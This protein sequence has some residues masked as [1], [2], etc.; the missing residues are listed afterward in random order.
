MTQE[1]SARK[2]TTPD[3]QLH[4]FFF[5]QTRRRTSSA[6]AYGWRVLWRL[7]GDLQMTFN[8]IPP[9]FGSAVS[10]DDTLTH[11]SSLTGAARSAQTRSLRIMTRACAVVLLCSPTAM[12]AQ[13]HHQG[14]GGG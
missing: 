3:T 6:R 13:H 4:V 8:R 9:S 14:G 1:S 11:N 10:A 5:N 2:G 12:V 7:Q